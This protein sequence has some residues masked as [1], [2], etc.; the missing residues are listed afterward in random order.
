M[1]INASILEA[2]MKNYLLAWQK[3]IAWRPP[4]D[5]SFL[6]EEFG[7]TSASNFYA[8]LSM[9]PGFREWVGDRVWNDVI[10]NKFEIKNRPFESSIPMERDVIADSVDGG[11]AVYAP[12]I[13]MMASAWPQLLHELVVE[14]LTANPTTF[15]GSALFA[16]D[17][18]YGAQTI[19]NLVT[20]ALSETTF[21][22]AFVTKTGYAWSNGKQIPG[23]WT[24]LM[25]GEKNRKTAFNLVENKYLS[26]TGGSASDNPNAG[27]CK[28]VILPEY[29]GAYDDYWTLVD[30]SGPM[31]AIARQIRRTPAP[32]VDTRPEELERLSLL[33]YMASGRAAAGPTFP[34]L[35]YGGRL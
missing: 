10:S 34:H 17:H 35:I 28:L 21:N 30:A 25:V 18:A 3:G 1:D 20:D 9:I 23:T 31:K 26:V 12:I 29:A 8:W 33:R 11:Y 7:S 15:T 22:A 5:L 2:L 27:K 24:H 13:T 4:V 32:M 14:V 6:V 19:S 16:T